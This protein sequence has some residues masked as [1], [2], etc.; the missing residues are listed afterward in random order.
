M[1]TVKNLIKVLSVISV[2]SILGHSFSAMAADGDDR[3]FRGPYV[4][5]EIGLIRTDHPG[6]LDEKVSG[7]YYGIVVGYRART[8]GK[9]VYGLEAGFAKTSLT[10]DAT[11]PQGMAHWKVKSSYYFEGV[12][13]VVVKKKVLIFISGGY[14]HAT[15]REDIDGVFLADFK[16]G[17]GRFGG[18]IEVQVSKLVSIRIKAVKNG[19]NDGGVTSFGGALL[20]NF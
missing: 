18:G 12:V 14:A 3:N 5:V 13:G 9:F 17:V 11:I 4:G 1:L 15:L 2:F 20:I 16:D 7:A 8:K 6:G 10:A 19:F